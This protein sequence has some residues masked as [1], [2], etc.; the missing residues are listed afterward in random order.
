MVKKNQDKLFC[1]CNRFKV[2]VAIHIPK[3]R[4][5]RVSG[6]CTPVRG[7]PSPLQ[8]YIEPLESMSNIQY[9][10]LATAEEKKDHVR[11]NCRGQTLGCHSSLNGNPTP[12]MKELSWMLPS[13]VSLSTCIVRSEPTIDLGL[14]GERHLLRG[15]YLKNQGTFD[16]PCF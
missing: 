7:H 4:R 1:Q 13:H 8:D 2:V 11:S 15:I 5:Y 14:L 12:Q 6:P 9:P 10:K 3:P 16:I